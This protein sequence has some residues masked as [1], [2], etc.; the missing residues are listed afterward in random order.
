MLYFIICIAHAIQTN[1]K[2]I[3]YA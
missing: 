2:L 3:F 1:I